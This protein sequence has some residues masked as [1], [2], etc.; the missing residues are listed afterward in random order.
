MRALA[1]AVLASLSTVASPARAADVAAEPR[2]V[3]AFDRISLRGPVDADVKVGAAQSVV[4]RADRDLVPRIVTRVEGTTLV[5]EGAARRSWFGSRSEAARVEISIPSLRALAIEGSGDA[6]VE[7]GQGELDLAIRGS[8][9]L[10]WRGDVAALSLAIRGSGDATVAGRADRLRVEVDGSGDVDA[11]ALSAG[12]A[13]VAVHGSGD[14]QV[15]LAGGP[16]RARV[17]GS[18]DVT[19]WGDARVEEASAAGSGSIRHGS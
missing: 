15:R 12:A 10:D 1:V 8:G 6:R 4:V 19:W 11:K 17:S 5:V 16:L 13:D 7:G 18:G 3:P 2:T 9:D 14:V